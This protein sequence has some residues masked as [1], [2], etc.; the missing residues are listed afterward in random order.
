MNERI[1]Q[2][3]VEMDAKFESL[4]LWNLPFQT[5]LSTLLYFADLI[6]NSDGEDNPYDYLGRLSYVFPKLK[7]KCNDLSLDNDSFTSM[8]KGHSEKYIEEFQFV[9]AYAHFSILQPQVRK[10]I[11]VTESYDSEL[12]KLKFTTNET[13]LSELID[14]LYS[15]MACE[16][17]IPYREIEKLEKFISYDIAQKMIGD[18]SE[19]EWMLKLYKHYLNFQISIKVLPEH[20]F[21]SNFGFSNQELVRFCAAFR[22]FADHLICQAKVYKS[23]GSDESLPYEEQEYWM[24]LYMGS[25]SYQIRSQHIELIKDVSG[26]SDETFFKILGYYT[27][28]IS[29]E[30][31]HKI[32]EVSSCGDGY[33]PPLTL[34]SDVFITSPHAIRGLL[35]TNN[36]LYSMN[37]TKETK[38]KFDSAVSGELEPVLINQVERLFRSFLGIKTRPNVD[39]G[40]KMGEIDLLVLSEDEKVCISIQIKATLAAD[41]TRTV[42]RVEDRV[43]EGVKQT[44]RFDNLPEREKLSLINGAFDTNFSE[45]KFLHLIVVRASAGSE[46][47][48]AHNK[49]YKIVNYPFLAKVL[50]EKLVAKNIVFGDIIN[51]I[52]I[53]QQVLVEESNYSTRDQLMNINSV[54]INFPIIEFDTDNLLLNN[55]RTLKVFHDFLEC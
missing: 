2:L 48:W 52:D 6:N 31:G 15:N 7:E 4:E 37:R 12:I 41:S 50:A 30:T 47:A 3:E 39:Y 33:F 21:Q 34:I 19:I 5:I 43:I 17:V 51:E 42:M 36:I 13:I 44:E 22:A 55:M 8:M 25:V 18:E 16:F 29:N 46:K 23:L 35:T 38:S 32:P 40:S 28:V 1:L 27:T 24:S 14:R 53:A 54:N 49:K 45:I 10:S 26:L 9:I 11:L 20:V